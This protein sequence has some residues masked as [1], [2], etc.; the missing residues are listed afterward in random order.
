MH[1][2]DSLLEVSACFFRAGD[3]TTS[4]LED[5]YT[6][7]SYGQ[8][9]DDKGQE[10]WDLVPSKPIEPNDDGLLRSFDIENEEH[11]IVLKDF[12]GFSFKPIFFGDFGDRRGS[13]VYFDEL[14]LEEHFEG[15]EDDLAAYAKEEKAKWD[16]DRKEHNELPI[17][18]RMLEETNEV[19]FI[20]ALDYVSEQ[21][22][23]WESVEYETR[24]EIVGKVDMSR[25]GEIL[26]SNNG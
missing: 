23:Y 24:I 25:I 9:L 15:C 19:K 1:R 11:Y 16:A 26:V 7:T 13:G 6:F 20:L 10:Y 8:W 2:V 21:I 18:E 4:N 22:S 3:K 12:I 17:R 5:L 14:G